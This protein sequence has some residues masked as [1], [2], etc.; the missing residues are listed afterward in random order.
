MGRAGGPP[1]LKDGE[2]PWLCLHSSSHLLFTFCS[3]AESLD[4]MREQKDGSPPEPPAAPHTPPSTPVKLEEGELRAGA[5]L[6]RQRGRMAVCG[7]ASTEQGCELRVVVSGGQWRV[8]AAEL[9][10]GAVSARM[11]AGGSRF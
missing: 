9:P 6:P 8:A 7:R 10:L 3:P 4:E 11:D 2:G 5:R 1:A